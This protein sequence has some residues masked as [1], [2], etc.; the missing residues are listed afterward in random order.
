MKS[1]P[2]LRQVIMTCQDIS[3]GSGYKL[4]TFKQVCGEPKFLFTPGY[5]PAEQLTNAT[6]IPKTSLVALSE[7]RCRMYRGRIDGNRHNVKWVIDEEG[8]G[9]MW[10]V[11]LPVVAVSCSPPVSLG[12]PSL[13]YFCPEFPHQTYIYPFQLSSIWPKREK[14]AC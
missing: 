3:K 4:E 10:Y 7:G 14:A 9:W 13:R 11:C 1:F 2:V 8:V 5:K 12:T 6:P